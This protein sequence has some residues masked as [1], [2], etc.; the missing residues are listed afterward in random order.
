MT[1][2]KALA[3]QQGQGFSLVPKS[4][5]EAMEFATIL[6]KSD[7]V[8]KDYKGK[9]GN[10]LVAVQMGLDLG[11]SPMQAIQN[12]AVINGRPC[13][14][15]DL[16]L[17]IVKAHPECVDIIEVF[18]KDLMIA[19]C[20]TKRKGK[21]PVIR[22]FS[23]KEA[24][25]ANLWK[26]DGPW[27][28]YP[29]RMLQMRARSF[30]LRDSFPDAL[31]G[32]HQGEEVQD[33]PLQTDPKPTQPPQTTEP[34]VEGEL[35]NELGLQEVIDKISNCNAIP[36]VD[37]IEI[38]YVA[39]GGW[40]EQEHSVLWQAMKNKRMEITKELK[41]KPADTRTPADDDLPDG[42][43]LPG[44]EPQGELTKEQL[45]DKA[46]EL[47]KG[48]QMATSELNKLC[49]EITK[50]ENCKTPNYMN[51]KQLQDLVAYLEA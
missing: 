5:G 21:T 29:E 17:A 15:G 4:L 37:N 31:K 8:P 18:D 10:V 3:I 49:F 28:N 44:E 2:K 1:E 20:T 47:I 40:D 38:K 23:Q 43:L 13:I 14:W 11:V 35:V 51:K 45:K 41:N 16:Q 9:P 7:L 24:E 46:W 32:I 50:D 30:A 6:A 25:K 33:I 34:V 12:I 39:N 19:T 27:T 26:K 42:G 48:K 22:Q 36:H